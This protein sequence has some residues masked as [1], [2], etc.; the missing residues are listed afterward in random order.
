LPP[1]AWS[2]RFVRYSGLLSDAI[3][4]GLSA[5]GQSPKEAIYEVLKTDFSMRKTD[6]PRRFAEFSSIL[7]ENIGP[8][9]T[10]LLEFIV[11]RFSQGLHIKSLSSINLD[12]SIKRVDMILKGNLTLPEGGDHASH[13]VSVLP[14]DKTVHDS[15]GS[16]RLTHSQPGFLGANCS[17]AVSTIPQDT[18]KKMSGRSRSRRCSRANSKA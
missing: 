6:I 8:G 4:E 5:L 1:D 17:I 11:D 13:T 9:A 18:D 16:I 7:K 12:E 14:S 3:D 15:L 10:P 2:V